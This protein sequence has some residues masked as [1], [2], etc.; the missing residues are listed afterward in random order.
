MKQL[1]N[2]QQALP[3]S[4]SIDHRLTR[5]DRLEKEVQA[6]KDAQGKGWWNK[7]FGR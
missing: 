3:D 5:L 4:K 2:Q 6:L 7:F 1:R